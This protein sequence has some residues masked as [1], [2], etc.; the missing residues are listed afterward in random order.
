MLLID[1]EVLMLICYVLFF[2][3][4]SIISFII[5]KQYQCVFSYCLRVTESKQMLHLPVFTRNM[6]P[7]F[8]RVVCMS[9]KL[10]KFREIVSNIGLLIIL[11]GLRLQ[12]KHFS[13]L[14]RAICH[15]IP[16]TFGLYPKFCQ[17]LVMRKLNISLVTSF[18][19]INNFFILILTDKKIR[20]HGNC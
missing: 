13:H 4:L 7:P 8:T 12:Q 6:T 16:G 1:I 20:C 15:I 18:F 19:K 11:I 17:C 5:Q 14:L 3:L 9:L 10:S 2:L